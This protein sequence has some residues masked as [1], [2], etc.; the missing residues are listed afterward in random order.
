MKEEMAFTETANP[1]RESKPPKIPNTRS[2]RTS[3]WKLIFNEHNNSTPNRC[4]G[5]DAPIQYTT[6]N[7]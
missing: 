1:L 4:R 7:E 5:F 6:N 2:I 3:N